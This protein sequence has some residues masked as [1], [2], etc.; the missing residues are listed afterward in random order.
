MYAGSESCLSLVHNCVHKN[1]AE[2][3]KEP[4][5]V[6]DLAV[7]SAWLEVLMLTMI[8]ICITSSCSS[9]QG[10]RW[11]VDFDSSALIGIG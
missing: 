9:H 3:H 6:S 2:F 7:C 8:I 4:G 11:A 1:L 5:G 10:R